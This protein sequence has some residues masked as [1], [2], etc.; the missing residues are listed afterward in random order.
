MRLNAKRSAPKITWET[1][2]NQRKDYVTIEHIFPQNDDD[3][4]WKKL[5]KQYDDEHKNY[6]NHSLGNL[7]PLSRERNSTFQNYSFP[8]KKNNGNGVGYY[9]GSH[10]EIEVN[11]NNNDWNA[12][13]ILERGLE[14]LDFMENR[15]NISIGDKQKK[16]ELL[17]L[18]FLTSEVDLTNSQNKE[19]RVDYTT[20]PTFN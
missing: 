14:M 19:F 16:I 12:Q 3:S 7:L 5:Y 4:Y 17:H 6:L 15:W 20:V 10:S 13:D 11:E 9:N 8:I 1:F 2:I 18:G